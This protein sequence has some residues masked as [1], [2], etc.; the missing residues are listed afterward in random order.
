[1]RKKIRKFLSIC[2]ALVCSFGV[3]ATTLPAFAA[4]LGEDPYAYEDHECV[5]DMNAEDIIV[6]IK[7]KGC[8][9]PEIYDVYKPCEICGNNVRVNRVRGESYGGHEFNYDNY[10]I[11]EAATC[12]HPIKALTYCVHCGEPEYFEIG[13]CT[14]HEFGHM[15]I[16]N[17]VEPHDGI[18]GGYTEVYY[19]KDC[20]EVYATQDILV[21]Y[22][23]CDHNFVESERVE[24]TCVDDGYV[25]YVC[26]E[27]NQ[28]KTEVLKA[29]GIHTPGE[30]E[31][32]WH[33]HP[34]CTETGQYSSYIRCEVCGE[35]LE[36]SSES[37]VSP[38]PHSFIEVNEKATKDHDGFIGKECSEC[39]YREGEIVHYKNECSHKYKQT[40]KAKATCTSE[41]YIEYTCK[42]CGDSYRELIPMTNH[43]YQQVKKVKATCKS[44]GY[45]LYKCKDCGD[46]YKEVIPMTDHK[47][48]QVKKVDATYFSDGYIE[49][50]CK[51]CGDTYK[52]VLPKLEK[53]NASCHKV[54][55]YSYFGPCSHKAYSYNKCMKSAMKNFFAKPYFGMFYFGY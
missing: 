13:E 20:G 10:N 21:K 44:E 48:Q 36:G 50:R 15:E 53:K 23:E 46:T 40:A 2:L 25:K 5:P 37:V 24:A 18:D 9:T 28:E 55:S 7:D 6:I 39:G 30:K 51:E 42:K 14:D 19:C 22:V 16:T 38:L 45:I 26:S 27:C 54:N 47:Y 49:Y 34:T 8:F 4:E 43:K 52:E 41:G 3:T 33:K 35:L 32:I 12:Q 11:E 31:V 1:M 17:Q 29:T